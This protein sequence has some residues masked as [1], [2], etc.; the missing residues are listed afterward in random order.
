LVP[1][2]FDLSRDGFEN[3]V[4]ISQYVM[5]PKADHSVAMCFDCRRSVSVAFLR[6]LPTVAL[7]RNAERAANEID[8]TIAD[9]KLPSEL[10]AEKIAVPKVS[11]K[12]SLG[13]RHIVAQLARGWGE[14]LF[15]HRGTPIPNP[16]PQGMGL[17]HSI[18]NRT[19]Q[20]PSPREGVRG[21]GS[22]LLISSLLASPIAAQNPAMT[23]PPVADWPG[24]EIVEGVA[25]QGDGGITLERAESGLPVLAFWRPILFKE[26]TDRPVAGRMDCRVV[27]ADDGFTED[28]FDPDALHESVAEARQAQGFRDMDRLRDYSDTVRQ[29]DVV[30]RRANPRSHYVLSYILVRDGERLI[31][32]RRNCTFVYGSGVSRPDVLPYVYRYTRFSYAFEPGAGENG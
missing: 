15:R 1:R 2:D 7:D 32:I 26:D 4:D 20:S 3:A 27:A 8:D 13:I 31:D 25:F 18:G 21:G 16:F 30:G 14:S 28:A 11:P 6:M 9:R 23:P 22:A 5:V 24:A 12:R 19:Q 29:L 10:R 17:C